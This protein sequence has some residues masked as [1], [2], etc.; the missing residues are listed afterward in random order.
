MAMPLLE[1]RSSPRVDINGEVA[2]RISDSSD[3]RY[4]TIENL[5]AGGA[6]VWIEEELP[7][8]SRLLL[9][10]VPKNDEE[11]VFQFEAIVLH[12]LPA[13]KDAQHGYRCQF[14]ED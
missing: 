2:Y 8:A 3:F 6:L 9:R 7:D 11:T 10:T 12:K 5:S 4:G 1:R 13:Q 14:L